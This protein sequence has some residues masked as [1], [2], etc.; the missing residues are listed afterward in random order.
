MT[1]STRLGTAALALTLF[2]SSDAQAIMGGEEDDAH[3]AAVAIGAQIDGVTYIRCSGTVIAPGLVLTA[4]H[5]DS[6]MTL[7]MVAAVG[8]VFFGPD[9]EDPERFVE[10]DQVLRH[11]DYTDTR[12]GDL[13]DTGT[14]S[15]DVGLLVL[16][17]DVDVRPSLL[18]RSPVTEDHLGEGLLAVGYGKSVHNVEDWGRRRVTTLYIDDFSGQHILSDDEANPTGGNMCWGDVGAPLFYDS[19]DGNEV[20]WA[21]AS[22]T[23][24]HCYRE[25]QSTPVAAVADWVFERVEEHTGTQ[26]LCEVNGFYDDGTCDSACDE[27]DPDCSAEEGSEPDDDEAGGPGCNSVPV[28]S[29]WGLF[30]LGVVGVFGRRRNRA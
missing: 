22:W 25:T 5:C 1:R 27:P 28:R 20:Q 11:P 16:A 2:G 10:V 18:R 14:A 4:A 24:A 15:N 13:H 23:D 29:S 6:E 7:D 17:E 8:G 3:H 30:A 26:D 9:A 19:G 21:I 12:T